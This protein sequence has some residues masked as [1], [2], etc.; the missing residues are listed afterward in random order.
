MIGPAPMC[1][2]CIHLTGKGLRCSAFPEGIPDEI[3]DGAVKH[4]EAYEGDHGFQFQ[5]DPEKPEPLSAEE[6]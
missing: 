3:I 2:S 5:Q 1:L 4:L 6:E